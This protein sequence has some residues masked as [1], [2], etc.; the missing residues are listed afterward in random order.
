MVLLDDVAQVQAR[1]SLFGESGNLD[2]KLVHGLRRTYH[3]IK[4]ILDAPDVSP[5]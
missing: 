5:R 4:I 1:F 2:A 3:R